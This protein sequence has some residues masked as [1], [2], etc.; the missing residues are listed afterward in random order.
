M[1]SVDHSTVQYENNGCELSYQPTRQQETQMRRFRS[2]GK[3]SV[4]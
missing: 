2:Q 4:F 3:L 1:P